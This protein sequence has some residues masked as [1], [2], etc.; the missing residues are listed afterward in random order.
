MKL[1]VDED[2]KAKILISRLRD[3]GHDVVSTQDIGA[4][5]APDPE[6]FE[7]ARAMGRVILTKNS[8]DYLELHEQNKVPG[9]PGVLAI[10]QDGDPRK[11]MSYK[12]I[13]QAIDNVEDAGISMTDQ[14][15]VVNAW[16]YPSPRN[17][18]TI[19]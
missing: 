6:V 11:D 13:V 17:R 8:G 1:L 2:T 16:N 12:D 3:A 5:S 18:K 9:H 19:D 15:I 7:I 10:H 4:D 14:F